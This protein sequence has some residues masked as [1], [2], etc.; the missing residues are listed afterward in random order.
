M[1]NLLPKK[2]ELFPI[3]DETKTFSDTPFQLDWS[4]LDF[5][6]KLQIA[7]DLVRQ[8]MMYSEYPDPITDFETLI[9]DSYT[10]CNVSIEY[11]RDLGLGNNYRIVLALGK[12]YENDDAT[13]THFI[14]L[15]DDGDTTYQFDA[16]PTVGYKCGKVEKITD[17]FYQ[18]Y[19]SLS[20]ETK[21]L[22]ESLRSYSYLLSIKNCD[23]K[24][25]LEIINVIADAKK[26]PELKGM[27]DK[28]SSQLLINDLNNKIVIRN[29]NVEKE[30][31]FKLMREWYEELRSLIKEDKNLVRQIELTQLLESVSGNKEPYLL[32][33]RNV[34]PLSNLTPRF[35]YENNLNV[36]MVKPSAY[37]FG[38]EDD[39]KNRFLKDG[40]EAIAPYDPKFDKCTNYGLTKMKL[41][42]SHG[43]KYIREMKGP[44]EMF[45]IKRSVDEI[46]SIKKKLR[47]ELKEDALKK[48]KV[49]W[50][51]GHPI[52]WNPICL[53]FA[54]TSDNPS[55]ASMNYA[56]G[57][58]E[59]QVMTR[60]MYPN[61]VLERKK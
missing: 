20:F 59:Y 19:V 50:F 24:D 9:G 33:D 2:E 28:V 46:D 48:D 31:L 54:H 7:N 8:T 10:A 43:Y 29:D 61:L 52:L 47:K 17:K 1:N 51:D 22:Y 36:V 6:S 14:L 23:E 26:Y 40:Y 4:L 56:I 21:E 30:K 11:L 53:N 41:F 57:Y 39:I 58:P 13:S 12:P 35:Y 16:T 45:L 42:H 37:I 3:N 32:Y 38:W 5:K 55:E 34:Y 18:D 60:F 25:K 15:I 27:I 49:I 44:S